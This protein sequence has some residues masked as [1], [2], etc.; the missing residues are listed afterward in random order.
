MPA[1]YLANV[2]CPSKLR[3]SDFSEQQ[4][5]DRPVWLVPT[6][7]RDGANP[8]VGASL[9]RPTISRFDQRRAVQIQS[10][11]SRSTHRR[12]TYDSI[13]RLGPAKVFVPSL[14]TRIEQSDQFASDRIQ[15]RDAIRFVV[16]AQRTS[17]PKIVLF[18]EPAQRFRNDDR[19]PLVRR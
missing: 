5:K 16:V 11:H 10:S 18:R 6:K 17:Q 8:R 1:E 19:S 15:G 7:I 9:R 4:K 3:G 2:T 12:Q 14:M 13:S